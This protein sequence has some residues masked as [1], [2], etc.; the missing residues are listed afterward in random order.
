VRWDQNI[1]MAT[2]VRGEAL[3]L[4]AINDHIPFDCTWRCRS[5]GEYCSR[6]LS[7]EA[8][9]TLIPHEPGAA[10]EYADNGV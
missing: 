3:G 8:D 1:H 6:Y 7:W 9:P 10:G 2:M 4:I 5:L